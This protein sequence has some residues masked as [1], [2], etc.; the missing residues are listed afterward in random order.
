MKLDVN[1]ALNGYAAFF[2]RLTPETVGRLGEYVSPDVQFINPFCNVTGLSK[3]EH[4]V[5]NLY[6][7]V[8][9]PQIAVT[10]RAIGSRSCYLRWQ[11]TAHF[12]GRSR[13][14]AIDGVSEIRFEQRGLVILH[15]DHW[16]S[17]SQLY[18]HFPVLRT[19]LGAIRRYVT[20]A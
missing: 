17:A 11:F 18:D 8:E 20:E 1:H 19:V 14:F 6:T 9:D 3:M 13:T 16:D 15:H 4:L 5:R 10:D 7:D 12:K 2:E